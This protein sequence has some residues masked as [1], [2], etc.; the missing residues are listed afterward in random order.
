MTSPIEEI[1][2]YCPDLTLTNGVQTRS[3]Y[4]NTESAS[5][6]F[7]VTDSCERNAT[8]M[9]ED[10]V[11]LIFNLTKRIQFDAFSYIEYAGQTFFLKEAYRPKNNGTFRENGQA[12]S[13]YYS[14]DMKFV[15]VSNMLTKH[16]CLRN[17]QVVGESWNEPE[18]NINGTLETLYTMII[19]SIEQ[20]AH[21]IRNN[22]LY[23][24]HC[25]LSIVA[26]KDKGRLT[27]GTDLMTF[28][29][30]GTNIADALTTIA[31]GYD[32]TEWYIAEDTAHAF[33]LHICKCEDTE[34]SVLHLSDEEYT[35]TG[36][37]K[38][39][40]PTLSG[41]LRSC[42][43]AQEW[44]G[45]VERIMPFGSDRNMVKNMGTDTNT[46]MIVS[47]GKRLR[48]DPHHQV[49]WN[50]K[51]TPTDDM[52]AN[53]YTGAYIV[54]D[55]D[56]NNVLLLVDKDGAVAN[57]DTNVTTGI[58]Q[59][60]MYDDV[61]PQCHFKITKV[62]EQTKR[63]DGE[64]QPRYT[65]EGVAVDEDKYPKSVLANIGMFPIKIM[66][67]ETLSVLFESGYLNGREFEI[68][69]KTTKDAGVTEY[70]LRFTIV[71]D[72]D[73]AEGTLIPSGNF[74]PRVGDQ[75][76]L[77]N[78][79]MP[80]E[81]I[82]IAKDELAQKAYED[83]VEL[84]KTR[85]EVKCVAD[86][87]MFAQYD[88]YLGRRM[89]V[90][91]EIFVSD[92]AFVSRV[93]S[94]SHSLTSP[95]SVSFSLA[96]AIM[97]GTLSSMESAIGE[98][99]HAIGGLDQR[100]VN[101]SRRGWRDTAEMAE[102]LD[103][104][105]AEMMVVGVEKNQFAFTSAILCRNDSDCGTAGSIDHFH[106]LTIGNGTL[107]HT[108]KEWIDQHDGLWI[109]EP[110][111]QLNTCNLT[112][113]SVNTEANRA[114]PYYLYAFCQAD[115]EYAQLHLLD[116]DYC[117]A[118]NIEGDNQYLLLGILSSEFEDGNTSYRVFNRSNGYTAVV[119]GTITTEQIQDAN[120]SLIIDFQSNPPRIIARN[121]AEIIGSIKFKASDTLTAEEQLEALGIVA[122]EAKDTADGAANAAAQAKATAN[123]AQTAVDN[124]TNDGIISGGAEKSN[125]K[126]EWQAIAGENMLGT[127]DGS[128]YK[129]VVQAQTYSVSAAQM[130]NFF[131]MLRYAMSFI[132]QNPN[133]D[134]Y[135]SAGI[136]IN[137]AG[138]SV[139]N[140]RDNFNLLWKNYYD[141]EIAV[142]NAVSNKIKAAADAAQ[143]TADGLKW[144]VI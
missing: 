35:N 97:Q 16:T 37:D 68:T 136:P 61:Y 140:T 122:G 47:Y 6:D 91:S 29:F 40:H 94:F 2:I 55:K 113:E 108:Q 28:Q 14:Y 52:I 7:P 33:V 135:I 57:P 88:V 44:T 13:A 56:G 4:L 87:R 101:L 114:K 62:E 17:V 138:T 18:I 39:L 86:E 26:N 130:R 59:V 42:E 129:A 120:R 31:N 30:S 95:S 125:L 73:I 144:S 134:T 54:H 90:S 34:S 131:D 12:V 49:V 24:K 51:T 116:M 75:F 143:A 141:S 19:G 106:H 121:G 89:E 58:E 104:L 118:H 41:G 50:G 109:I 115:N 119:G 100:A 102:M 74:I 92:A 124:V 27:Q 137:S 110:I 25:L 53:G 32:E 36:A 83:L 142:L 133:A 77:F 22:N 85:P 78:M 45:I 105:A 123:A 69:N 93:I 23:Y 48:L 60:V 98:N 82:D 1:S 103:S 128:F 20:A 72:G 84:A 107:Q 5:G 64:L 38:N 126:R 81:F 43:Y 8:V 9:G 127:V 99:V 132:L 63:I 139:V 10:Y 21:R 67:A 111:D 79:K 112:D 46:N 76:A 80:D 70:S 11:R 3:R 66:E 65:I 96:S 15:S 117:A 71:A